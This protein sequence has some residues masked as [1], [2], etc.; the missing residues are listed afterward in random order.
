MKRLLTLLTLLVWAQLLLYFWL[1][2]R[3]AAYLHPQFHPYVAAAG[4]ALLV[5]T[6]L[7]WWA[8]ADGEDGCDH[9]E[10]HHDHAH[11]SEAPRG[12]GAGAVLSFAV[13]L[14]PVTAAAVISPSQFGEAAVMNRGL[15]TSLSQLPSAA[16]SFTSAP[17]WDDADVGGGELPDPSS[18]PPQEEGVE[19]FTRGPDGAIQLETMDMLYAAEEAPVREEFADQKVSVTGQYAPP[20]DDAAEGFNLVRMFIVCCAADAQPVAVMVAGPRP[21]DVPPMSW[22]RVTGIARFK[23]ENGLFIPGVEAEKVEQVE[24]PRETILY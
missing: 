15:V 10:E 14:L 1:S 13:L 11:H 19:Y 20:T 21:K 24:A 17:M 2:G 12:L 3:V 5:L 23:A 7:Y 18:L 22:I 4:V 16:P 8:S 9:C 6:V